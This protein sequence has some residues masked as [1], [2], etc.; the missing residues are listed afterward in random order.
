[1]GKT[2]KYKAFTVDKFVLILSV[3][4]QI[5][6]PEQADK[7]NGKSWVEIYSNISL[8]VA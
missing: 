5:T 1:M 3:H 7:H 4:Q 6:C 2:T 8:Y